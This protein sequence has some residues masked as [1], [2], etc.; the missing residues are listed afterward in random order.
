[1]RPDD[2]SDGLRVLKFGG[3]SVGSA[4]RIRALASLV[5]QRTDR[6]R[7]V[8]VVSALS[9]VTNDLIDTAQRAARSER[10]DTRVGALADRHRAAA[11]ELASAA[12]LN[13]V[14]ERL[15][16]WFADLHSLFHGVSLVRDCSPRVL[17]AI[18][19]HGE[20]FA[21]T[22]VAAALRAAGVAATMCDA[23]ELIVTDDTFGR[24]IVDRTGT[25]TRVRAH[26]WP[27]SIP[28]VTG[29]IAATP[30]G[31]T[32]TLGRGG[33]D[34]TATLL[35]AVLDAAAVEI[36]TDVDGVMSA[37]PRLVPQAFAL[38]NLSY[39]ELMELS[40]FG[41]K[42]M[43]PPSV[44]PAREAFL[45]LVIRNTFNPSFPGTWVLPLERTEAETEAARPGAEGEPP[46]RVRPQRNP[47]CG[48]SSINQVVL[49]RLQ[50]AGMVGVSG[51][52][53]RLFGALARE[54]I[55]VI[56]ISQ[57]S[58][59]HSICFALDPGSSSAARRRVDAEF[60]LERRAGAVDPL[61]M[62]EGFAVVAAVGEGMRETPGI[63]GKLFDVLGRNG[64]NV[65]AIAQ[66]S[67]ELNISL[68]IRRTDEERA[69]RLVHDAFFF[70]RTRV[71]QVFVAG[72]GRVGAALLDQMAAQA[73]RLGERM[74]LRLIIAGIARR[75]VAALEPEGLALAD[76]R[77]EIERATRP[78][79]ELLQ[80]AVSSPHAHRVFVDC[81]ASPEIASVYEALLQKGVALVSAN[82][83][84]FS[85]SLQRYETLRAAGRQGNGLYTETTV[86][87]GLPVLRPIA[88]LVATGDVVQRVDGVLSGTLSF[89]FS[90]IMQGT[91]FSAAVHEAYDLGFTEPD[92]RDDLSGRDVLRKLL[93]LGREAGF[94]IEPE[95]VQ[96]ES[97]LPGEKWANFTIDEFWR[98]LPTLD[99]DF[100]ARRDAALQRNATLSYLASIDQSGANVAVREIERTHPCATLAPGDNLIAVT[101]ARYSERPLII[102]GPGA[103]PDVTAAGV[104]ADILRAAA[105]AR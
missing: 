51:I 21:A 88:D 63:A 17:D 74:G 4:E 25:E 9:G 101:S 57:A 80:A 98:E 24:A 29:F 33:S 69:L 20:L 91:P 16:Q 81:T 35:G 47:V 72:T 94:G 103:G 31:T 34:F 2:Q 64:I 97:V 105:E 44:A 3:T 52:A 12:E 70:P 27:G 104:F 40:H 8:I 55:S 28:V 60:E 58:S 46:P 37:D 32:T 100:A 89:L 48:I 75:S 92:P 87:A 42:V 45:P 6:E 30:D 71:V 49:C 95:Q 1:M 62:E 73:D 90:R 5:A 56:L 76:W 85:E 102:R 59:E 93:I 11:R 18:L 43:Y 82:K 39:T 83:I 53:T 67:S 86:G 23:R 19:A 26:H 65:R 14:L 78:T 61:I 22:L 54:G 36:W 84:A 15:E 50:G 96:R 38:S 77:A 68:V 13:G 10:V 41:A 66:G 99:A 7:L 79:H